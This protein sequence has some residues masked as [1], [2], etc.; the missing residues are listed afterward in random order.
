MGSV[1]SKKKKEKKAN[2]A[3]I[4]WIQTHTKYYKS[5]S[6]KSKSVWNVWQ[7]EHC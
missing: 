1:G 3:Q 5:K 2:A 4:I 7:F 6:Y